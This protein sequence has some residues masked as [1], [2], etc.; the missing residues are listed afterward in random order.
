MLD[1]TC[2]VGPFAVPLGR[3]NVCVVAND[4][5]AQ[6]YHYLC[7]NVAANRVEHNVVCR[8]KN[9]VE[10]LKYYLLRPNTQVFPGRGELHLG[11]V[12]LNLPE[13]SIEFL[14]IYQSFDAN[15]DLYTP[16]FYIEAFTRSEALYREDIII[17]ICVQRIGHQLVIA[18]NIF[19][20]VV[21][22]STLANSQDRGCDSFDEEFL[23]KNKEKAAEMAKQLFTRCVVRL[24]RDVGTRKYMVCVELAF[25]EEFIRG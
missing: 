11:A 20:L 6:S 18:R 14:N 2:G 3:A 21:D 17:R 15:Q 9:C 12:I 13:L 10:L 1:G 19:G 24:V 23:E 22:D 5:N 4:L 25:N 8:N 7:H 16:M